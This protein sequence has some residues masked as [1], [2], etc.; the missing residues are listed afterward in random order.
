MMK[1]RTVLAG[2]AMTAPVSALVACT[3]ADDDQV[4]I[5]RAGLPIATN[6]YPWR[7]FAQRAKRPFERKSPEPL[8]D[9][10][11]IGFAGYEP[12]VESTTE[13]AELT[14][15]IKKTSLSLRSV[16]V[17]SVLHD[18]LQVKRSVESVIQIA[19]ALKPLG[20][21]IIVTNPSPI[22]WGGNEDKTDQQLRRQAMAL[23]ELGARLGRQGQILA[24]HNH[25]AELR[26]GGREFHHM[27]TSTDPSHVRLC[28][29]AHWIYRGCGNSAVAL[30]D[31]VQHYHDRIVE[32]HLRQSVDGIWT[33]DFRMQGDVDYAR[34]FR[35]LREQK[36]QPHLV[37][38]QAVESESPNTM[39][40]VQAHQNSFDHLSGYL[41]K[42]PLF[43]A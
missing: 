37:L 5:D 19:S 36:I 42:H 7:T 43:S 3:S 40:A 27:L 18:E 31:A 32:L 33:E 17:N 16:Y 1:R 22:R 6:S 9:I 20:T 23:D 39:T 35:F 29:D 26:Q 15:A 13:A 10:Q 8:E 21:E 30:F 2:L 34:L 11:Q 41:A 4:P 12:I 28:L 14:S 24:Y 38:E 25:D